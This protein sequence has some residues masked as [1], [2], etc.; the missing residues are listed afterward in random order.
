MMKIKYKIVRIFDLYIVP[1]LING[2][3][4]ES[5]FNSMKEKYPNDRPKKN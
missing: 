2:N 5:Y 1:F 3:K 4:E